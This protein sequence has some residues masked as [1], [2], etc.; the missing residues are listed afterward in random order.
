VKISQRLLLLFIVIAIVF[1][2]FF[3]LFNYIK[4]EEMK[5]YIEYDN[6][7]QRLALNALI[8]TKSDQQM[9]FLDEFSINDDIYSAVASHNVTKAKNYLLL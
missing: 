1:G 5:V 7:Q 4:Q 2:A 3:Y 9:R 6:N 8:A